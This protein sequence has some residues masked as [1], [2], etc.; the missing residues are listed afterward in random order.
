MNHGVFGRLNAALERAFPEKRL[1][2]KSEAGTR[3]VR[4]RPATQ[5]VAL[6]GGAATL[7]WSIFASSMLIMDTIGAGNLREQAEREQA[8]Y[9]QR[10]NDLADERDVRGDEARRA[11]DRFSTALAQ[12]S[13]MQTA[14]LASEERRKELETGIG[15]IQATLRHT[16]RERDEAQAVTAALAAEADAASAGADDAPERLAEA[17]GTLDMIADALARTATERDTLAGLAAEKE[18]MVEDLVLEA[19]LDA[20][21]NER[22]FTHLEEAVSVSLEPL[23]KMFRAVGLD[24]ESLIKQVRSGYGASDGLGR[25]SISTKGA[26][27]T[28]ETD[29]ANGILTRLDDMNLY[30]IAAEKAPFAEPL[31]TSYRFTSGFGPR[32]GRMHKGSDF[33]S[34]HGTPV[35]ATADGVVSFAGRQSGYGNVVKIKH[36]FGIETTYA[37]NSKLRVS[38]GESVSRGDHIADMGNT[39]NSTGTHLHYEVRVNGQAVDPMTY[40]K[41]AKDVF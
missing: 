20:E 24:P 18:T 21:R 39:G 23:D 1:F 16:M 12:V 40:I 3:F 2:L 37:H 26:L 25:L 8:A 28:P 27:A 35:H 13:Q 4:L 14:L 31:K 36:A 30:R 11:Q 6:T 29:R 10:L 19:Q 5:L 41:A 15:V 38:V 9:E 32:W 33:A 17:V 34:R 22:I 7:G